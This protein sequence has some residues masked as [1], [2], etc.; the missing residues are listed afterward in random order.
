MNHLTETEAERFRLIREE[1]G[2]VAPIVA[3]APPSWEERD[4]ADRAAMWA[5]PAPTINVRSGGE[6][7]FGGSILAKGDI[8]ASTTK[9]E[10]VNVYDVAKAGGL[11][12]EVGFEPIRLDG[13]IVPP[14][15]GR[16][17]IREDT[18]APLAVVGADYRLSQPMD[19]VRLLDDVGLGDRAR[20]AG[21]WANG[22]E[23]WIQAIAGEDIALPGGNV[24][25]FV[26]A[27]S[28]CNGKRGTRFGFNATQVVCRNTY[29]RA[30]GETKGIK[31]TTSHDDRV[32]LAAQAVANAIKGGDRFAIL[33]ARMAETS[34]TQKTAEDMYCA[35]F[36]NRPEGTG[37]GFT[38]WNKD[39]G[40]FI[41]GYWGSPG[42][43]PGSLWGVAQAVTHH[44][45]HG[46]KAPRDGDGFRSAIDGSAGEAE[47]TMWAYV[48]AL[49]PTINQ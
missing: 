35:V 25:R 18:R 9:G 30:C 17:V 15:V 22:G 38:R 41:H 5:A 12:Y 4:D 11:N 42:A 31:H 40:R 46:A 24:K 48:H 49:I 34:A 47:S 45:Q 37:T 33:A 13:A 21:V 44:V 14:A 20:G 10:M 36:G 29:A 2:E 43:A 7:S 23:W 6:S 32:R 28:A 39:I 19:V 26:F 8:I 3:P 16:L 1:M 27:G